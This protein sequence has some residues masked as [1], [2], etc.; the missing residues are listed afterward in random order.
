MM[1]RSRVARVG[2]VVV[3]AGEACRVVV[4]VAA[5]VMGELGQIVIEE[6]LGGEGYYCLLG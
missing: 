4:V 5:V 6:K 1:K 2:E 3:V